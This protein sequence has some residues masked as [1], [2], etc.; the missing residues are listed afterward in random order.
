MLQYFGKGGQESVS[1][2]WDWTSRIDRIVMNVQRARQ[3]ITRRL[4]ARRMVGAVQLCGA[5]RHAT[6]DGGDPACAAPA[7]VVNWLKGFLK[8]FLANTRSPSQKHVQAPQ[9]HTS[10]V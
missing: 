8:G 1:L 10:C 7:R 9:P 3:A 5:Q 4:V 2:R 6:E